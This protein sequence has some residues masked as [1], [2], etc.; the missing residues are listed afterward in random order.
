MS[1]VIGLP[2]EPVGLVNI[3]VDVLSQVNCIVLQI[4]TKKQ[5]QLILA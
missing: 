2:L 4:T 3:L 1:D 5:S